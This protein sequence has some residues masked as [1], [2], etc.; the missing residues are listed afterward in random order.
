VSGDLVLPTGA[1]LPDNL[2]TVQSNGENLEFGLGMSP[3]VGPGQ[4]TFGGLFGIAWTSLSAE[5]APTLALHPGGA[6]AE[7]YVGIAAGYIYPLPEFFF[8]S[9]QLE[10]QLALGRTVFAVQPKDDPEALQPVATTRA[11]TFQGW[12][13]VGRRLF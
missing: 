4:L 1:T 3:P 5:T 10:E 6:T 8:L 12:L 7:P 11:W 13:L 2:G 9:G